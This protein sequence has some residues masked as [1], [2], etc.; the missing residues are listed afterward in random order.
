MKLLFTK[1]FVRDYRQLPLA[2]QK[3]VDK[4]LALLL[5]NPRHPSLNM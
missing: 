2:I 5:A 4:K 3:A 1:S